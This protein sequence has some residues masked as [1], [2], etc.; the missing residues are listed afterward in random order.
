[1]FK[2]VWVWVGV[3]SW[4]WFCFPLPLGKLKIYLPS[5]GK[6]RKK[7]TGRYVD[8]P[9]R[10][11][12]T[13][14]NGNLSSAGV[15]IS[16][17]HLRQQQRQRHRRPLASHVQASAWGREA[18]ATS[19][20]TKAAGNGQQQWA[21][22]TGQ[23][24]MLGSGYWEWTD[25]A[26]HIFVFVVIFAFACWLLKNSFQCYSNSNSNSN[27]D[28]NNSNRNRAASES[29]QAT[30]RTVLIRPVGFFFACANVRQFV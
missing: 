21:K 16:M 1:M 5:A 27:S 7:V 8:N 18:C 15:I 13:N 12:H 3:C 20:A 24:A 29:T 25:M 17:L 26:W 22:A 9:M 14:M 23:L 2:W 11:Y 4:N 28:S 19:V 6:C 30:A 10:V